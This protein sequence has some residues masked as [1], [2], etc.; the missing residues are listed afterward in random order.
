MNTSLQGWGLW[1]ALAGATIGTYICR[2]IGVL[3]AKR[4]NQDS[5]IFRYLSAV[6]YAMVAAL[7]VRMVL[8]PIG[9]LSTVPVW[10]RVLICILSISVLVSK[11][12][13]RLVSALLTGTLLTL[14][15]GLIR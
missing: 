5:E 7:V 15:Y 12:P 11:P 6:T 2:A 4:I 14:A 9:L 10:I 3:L 1:T 8:M 13:H